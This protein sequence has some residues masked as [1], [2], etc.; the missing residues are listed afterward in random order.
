MTPIRQNIQV[1][2]LQTVTR[3]LLLSPAQTQNLGTIFK[4]DSSDLYRPT[5]LVWVILP[6]DKVLAII[7]SYIFTKLGRDE[8]L[9]V[10]YNCCCLLARSVQ[11]RIQGGQ[12]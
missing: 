9:M 8:V 7:K 4:C 11:G 3:D 10:P 5:G 2:G 1:D 6:G 12:K